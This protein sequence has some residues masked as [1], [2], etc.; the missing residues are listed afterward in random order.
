[1]SVYKNIHYNEAIP[2]MLGTKMALVGK[3]RFVDQNTQRRKLEQRTEIT[4][5]EFDGGKR[6]WNPWQKRPNKK[7]LKQVIEMEEL[8]EMGER[9]ASRITT[10][11]APH[12]A[13]P[14]IRNEFAAAGYRMHGQVKALMK[15]FDQQWNIIKHAHADEIHQGE[16]EGLLPG[17]KEMLNSM[18]GASLMKYNFFDPEWY[19]LLIFLK[20]VVCTI[21]LN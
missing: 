1:M 11:T 17:E 3:L 9:R 14:S 18:P 4:Q 8:V 13:E 16:N 20:N 21:V 12:E 15:A 10:H 2:A 5:A 7:L 6:P 19:Y